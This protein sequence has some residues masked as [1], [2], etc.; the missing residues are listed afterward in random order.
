MD[1]QSLLKRLGI[2]VKLLKGDAVF[3]QGNQNKFLYFVEKGFLK[4]VY[5]SSDGKELVKSFLKEGDIIASLN[6][7]MMDRPST[8]TLICLEDT[9]LVK[10]PF[11]KL[12]QIS[13]SNSEV[14]GLV[15]QFL[16]KLA[17]KKEVREFELLSLSASERYQ[18]L[19][20]H[21]PDILQRATQND[22]ARYLGITPVALSRIRKKIGTK[23]Y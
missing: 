3:R 15:I 7:C 6:S 10:L 16:M 1:L 18:L 2:A 20:K 11:A 13:E 21:E 17:L 5:F 8:F 19:Q 4:A 23:S 12:M 14:T 9:K 22:I